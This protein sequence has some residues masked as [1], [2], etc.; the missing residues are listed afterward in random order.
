MNSEKILEIIPRLKLLDETELDTINKA[1][2]SCI[3]VQSLKNME[4]R[5]MKN[6]KKIES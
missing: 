3:I 6:F 4:K 1:I 5:E 2:D